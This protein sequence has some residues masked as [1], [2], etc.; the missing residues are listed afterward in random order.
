VIRRLKDAVTELQGV[1]AEQNRIT[2][3]Q[4]RTSAVL[5]KRIERL[6]VWLLVVTASSG[7]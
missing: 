3:E 4:N 5:A 1:V 6:N 7:R 2:A